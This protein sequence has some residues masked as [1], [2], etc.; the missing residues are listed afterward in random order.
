MA[1]RKPGPSPS[2]RSIL[3][4]SKPLSICM[5]SVADEEGAPPA[6]IAVDGGAGGVVDGAQPSLRLVAVGA[7]IVVEAAAR[8]G[9]DRDR[10]AAR[11]QRDILHP[12]G[13]RHAVHALL[14]DILVAGRIAA[15]L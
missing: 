3:P 4:E 15:D 13:V 8:A 10:R 2:S 5:R 6:S 7:E 12:D 11:R 1:R 9:I 14:I